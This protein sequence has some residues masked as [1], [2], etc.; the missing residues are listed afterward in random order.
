MIIL[1][2]GLFAGLVT[3]FVI[4]SVGS[5]RVPP[6]MPV[7]NLSPLDHHSMSPQPT[8]T[9]TPQTIAA[10]EVK[11]LYVPSAGINTPILPMPSSCQTVIDPPRD[12]ESFDKVYQCM[13][14]AMPG[15]DTK[16]NVVIA[17]HSSNYVD[18]V[19]NKLYTQGN[20]LLHHDVFIRTKASGKAWLRYS[21]RAVYEPEKSQLPYMSEV[22]QPTPGRL[23][24]VTCL[25]EPNQPY[26]V[27]NFIVVAQLVGVQPH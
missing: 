12:V 11:Q 1:M 5:A 16:T 13:D 9:P 8:H 7:P 17:G 3:T 25:Q 23:I 27:K 4:N 18:T 20:S 24:L 2:G 22:W 14:F 21:I 10:S 15:T 26:S 19:F 6:T